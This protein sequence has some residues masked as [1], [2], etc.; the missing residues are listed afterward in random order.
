M[1]S[2]LARCRSLIGTA[3]RGKLM[4]RQMLVELDYLNEAQGDLCETLQESLLG[5]ASTS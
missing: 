1:S 2:Q 3:K 4:P 5:T